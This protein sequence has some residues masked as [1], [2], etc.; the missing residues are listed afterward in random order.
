MV[1]CIWIKIMFQFL[2]YFVTLFFSIIGIC[3]RLNLYDS[4]SHNCENRFVFDALVWLLEPL[5]TYE[6]CKHNWKQE[7][8]ISIIIKHHNHLFGSSGLAVRNPFN[9]STSSSTSSGD[10]ND[11][12][13]TPLLVCSAPKMYAFL[14]VYIP[15]NT[16]VLRF[17]TVVQYFAY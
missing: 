7:S 14:W 1:L 9:T 12:S 10:N 11:T 8:L 3:V 13:Q 16:L 15:W 2:S 17:T 6:F 5:N 4:R